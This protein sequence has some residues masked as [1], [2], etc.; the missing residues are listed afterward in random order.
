MKKYKFAF[1]ARDI[2]ASRYTVGMVNASGESAK[3]AEYNARNLLTP[4]CDD[5]RLNLIARGYA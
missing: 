2:K 5:I 4:Y 3:D 1:S